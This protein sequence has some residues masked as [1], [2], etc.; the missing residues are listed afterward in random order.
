MGKEL[1]KH[2]LPE[3]KEII[4]KVFPALFQVSNTKY[5]VHDVN[6]KEIIKS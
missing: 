2:T 4:L 5:E 1:Q 6:F 3:W